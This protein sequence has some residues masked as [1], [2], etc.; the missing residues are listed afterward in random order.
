MNGAPEIVVAIIDDH[1]AIRVGM[2]AA[3][4]ASGR[5]LRVIEGAA[6]VADFLARDP[7][8]ADVVLLDL[9][10]GDGSDPKDNAE[11]LRAEGHRV[12]VYSIADNVRMLRRALAGGAD[13]VCR[14]AEPIA[15]TVE[16]IVAVHEGRQVISQE[17]LAAIEG[18]ATYVAAALGPRE[19]EVL[20]LYAAGL[21]IPPIGRTLYITEN[22]VKEYLKRIRAKYT[23][24]DRPAASKLELF[25]RAVED[26]IVPP[27]E[28]RF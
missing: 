26:G 9:N 13:G 19:R 8:D 23:Q 24:V 16:A 12:L 14:K 20:S 4:R 7:A 15:E 6:T 27:V 11:A 17:I 5:S 25:R 22:S 10:L 3:L 28:P 21:E 2:S 18:D 1:E